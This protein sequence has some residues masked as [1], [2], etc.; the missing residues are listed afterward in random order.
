MFSSRRWTAAVVLAIILLVPARVAAQKPEHPPIAI[1][2]AILSTSFDSNKATAGQ[3]IVLRSVNDVI[4]DGANII[5]AGSKIVAHVSDI[6][7]RNKER[8]QSAVAIVIEKATRQDGREIPLQG[9][10]A[11]MAAPPDIS[12]SSDPTCGTPR[13]SEPKMTGGAG[14][15]ARSGDLSR[16]SK[17]T[18]TATVATADLKNKM[19]E[20]FHLNADSKGAIGYEDISIS[21]GLALAPPVTILTTKAK[22]L[23]LLAG[24]QVLLRTL[25]PRGPN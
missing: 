12:L 20:P 17:A 18:A 10:I 7:I 24:T 23:K 19:D 3:E 21:W 13:A 5:P 8:P 16:S 22:C 4:M 11:A 25:P 9:I 15:A 6:A 1:I 2:F 14:N